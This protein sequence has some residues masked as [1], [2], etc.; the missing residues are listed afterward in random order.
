MGIKKGHG[1]RWWQ[2]VEKKSDEGIKGTM[3]LAIYLLVGRQ[4]LLYFG[5]GNR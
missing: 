4:L 3:A 5:G 1:K 2:K